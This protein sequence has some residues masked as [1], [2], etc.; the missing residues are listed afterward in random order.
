MPAFQR[1]VIP[2]SFGLSVSGA[3]APSAPAL[4]AGLSRGDVL[5]VV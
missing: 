2:R 3:V 4:F 1:F 5:K